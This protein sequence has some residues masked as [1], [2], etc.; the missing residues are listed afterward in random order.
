MFCVDKFINYHCIAPCTFGDIKLE[1]D[2]LIRNSLQFHQKLQFF[3]MQNP[4]KSVLPSS[5][6]TFHN[7]KIHQLLI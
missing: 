1:L 5:K 4:N 3:K 6:E 2:I 7:F